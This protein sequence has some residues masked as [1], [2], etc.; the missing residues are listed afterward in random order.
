MRQRQRLNQKLGFEFGPFGNGGRPIG[1]GQDSHHGNDDDAH[2][3]MFD[4]DVGTR[5]L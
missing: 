1:A 5:I 2:Q 3:R 4:I